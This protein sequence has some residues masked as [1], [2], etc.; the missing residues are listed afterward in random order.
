MKKKIL[1]LLLIPFATIAQSQ[2]SDE[3][4]QEVIISIIDHLNDYEEYN[5][6]ID[7]TTDFKQL[8]QSEDVLLINDLAGTSKYLEKITL[9]EYISNELDVKEVFVDNFMIHEISAINFIN[10]ESGTLSAYI[11]KTIE[12]ESLKYDYEDEHINYKDNFNLKLDISFTNDSIVITDIDL[13]QPKGELFVLT[14]RWKYSILPKKYPIASLE[15][16]IGGKTDWIG[17]EERT[18]TSISDFKP[19]DNIIIKSQDNDY[20]NIKKKHT[21]NDLKNTVKE[22]RLYEITFI[23]PIFSVSTDFVLPQN[24]MN[25][26]SAILNTNG[27]V[28][29]S[30]FEELSGSNNSISGSV[31]LELFGLGGGNWSF[32]FN[33][34]LKEQYDYTISI[35]EYT[36]NYGGGE[37][38]DDDGSSYLRDVVIKNWTESHRFQTTSE[39][40]GIEYNLNLNDKHDFFFSIGWG[41]ERIIGDNPTFSNSATATYKGTYRD[42]LYN[43]V[44]A[45]NGVYDYGTYDIGTLHDPNANDWQPLDLHSSIAAQLIDVRYK[46]NILSPLSFLVGAQYRILTRSFFEPSDTEWIS[47]F[48]KDEL[49]SIGYSD[50]LQTDLNHLSIVIGASIKL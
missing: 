28:A 50:L 35:P 49:N 40:Y 18:F 46:W 43:I 14:P 42:E 19:G 44:I 23:K 41:N 32:K 27:S 21:Y 22:D 25:I 3:R 34:T 31:S 29:S 15:I 1:I 9:S 38:I 8:F 12:L 47:S 2:V 13:Y 37:F 48:D 10:E 24:K 6:F 39:F 11:S 26:S 45:E 5:S 17:S 16:E 36:S 33:K 7:G 4:Y 20:Q 30:T